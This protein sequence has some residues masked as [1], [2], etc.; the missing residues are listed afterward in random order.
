VAGI[1]VL[2]P[3]AADLR[4]SITTFRHER[5]TADKVFGYL[6]KNHHLRCRPVTEQGLEAVRIST[7]VFN[8]R[9]EA[10]RVIAAVRAAAKDL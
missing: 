4:A 5:A 3:A 2:T 10:D 6:V 8:S 9:A 7:H 1:T